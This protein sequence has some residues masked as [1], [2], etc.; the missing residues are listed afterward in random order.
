MPPAYWN[1]RR[2][3]AAIAA[4]RSPRPRN[5]CTRGPSS[6]TRIRQS[7]GSGQGGLTSTFTTDLSGIDSE[8]DSSDTQYTLFTTLIDHGSSATPDD[9]SDHSRGGLN[10]GGTV[11]TTGH[12]YVITYGENTGDTAT[13]SYA[14]GHL[15]TLGVGDR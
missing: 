9:I 11:T 15:G 6:S 5:D 10:Q 7:V 13:D 1:P 4:A 14:W 12:C 8:T 3:G 2:A